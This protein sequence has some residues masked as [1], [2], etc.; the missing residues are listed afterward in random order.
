MMAGRSAPLELIQENAL[1]RADASE[2][3]MGNALFDLRAKLQKAESRAAYLAE[4]GRIL[5]AA[6]LDFDATIQALAR[7][8]VSRL[9]DWCVIFELE[10]GGGML[11][12]QVAHRDPERERELSRMVGTR[13]EERA[14]EA[15]L[16]LMTSG[17]SEIVNEVPRRIALGL[18]DVREGAARQRHPS[19]ERLMIIPLCARGQALGALALV[20]SDPLW[21]YDEEELSL[22]EELGSRAAIA[23]DNARLYNESQEANRAK[24][25]F[26]AIISHELRTPLNAIMGYSDLLETGISGPVS[27]KQKR[28]LGRVRASARHLLQLIEELLSFARMEG[29]E[30]EVQL[31]SVRA[32][33]LARE[34][35]AV[36][37]PLV[38]E[39]G[40]A[41][42]I[43]DDADSVVLETDVCKARRVLVNLLSNAFKFTDGG[44]VELRVSRAHEHVEFTIRDS[45]PGIPPEKLRRVF[46]PFW[47]AE[48][49]NTRCTGGIGMGLSVSRRLARMLRGDVVVASTAG[50]GTTVTVR[51]P[52]RGGWLRCTSSSTQFGC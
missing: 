24:A 36:V 2:E 14:S 23:M 16:R 46:E 5:V 35:G 45:G 39:K 43:I 50:V 1:R 41:F 33:D 38:I 37:E 28:H 44:R 8:A 34:A 47:Q 15:L 11:R 29:G 21:L 6:S 7:L 52:L 13:V 30:D 17:R 12:R 31:H 22:A 4:A 9:A 10:E 51:I 18:I 19:V 27:A 20:S 25:D 3:Q 32:I 49:P 26:L 42:H 40:H 48:E